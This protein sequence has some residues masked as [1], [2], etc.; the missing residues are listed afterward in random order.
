MRL[1]LSVVAASLLLPAI[2]LGGG[3]ATAGLSSTP[4]G[5]KPGEPWNVDV[6]ILQHGRTPMTNVKP[7]VLVVG[8]DGVE[9]RFAGS[10]TDEPGVYRA[11]VVFPEQGRYSYSVDDGFTNAM[12]HNFP[13]VTIGGAA[14][15]SAVAGSDDLPWWPLLLLAPV[16]AGVGVF[17][18]R[19]RG[20]AAPA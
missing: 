9:Q 20:S 8:P 13:A 15:T 4:A 3:F 17:L 16:L 19:R 14:P 2:A 10:R 18:V 1:L 6:T 7:A 12:P 11:R 5:V